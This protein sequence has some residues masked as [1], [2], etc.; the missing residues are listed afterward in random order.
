[1]CGPMISVRQLSRVRAPIGLDLGRLGQP[2]SPLS[3]LARGRGDVMAGCGQA[4]YATRSKGKM[5]SSPQSIRVI[6]Q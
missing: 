3:I 6:I 5:Q 1:M 4:F 2:R